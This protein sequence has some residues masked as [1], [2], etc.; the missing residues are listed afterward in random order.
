MFLI[1]TIQFSTIKALLYN[2]LTILCELR[3]MRT[4]LLIG[5]FYSKILRF[6]LKKYL[7]K[8]KYLLEI[9]LIFE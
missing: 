4:V 7:I 6:F 1:K 8:R 2:L 9:T 5:V 3:V